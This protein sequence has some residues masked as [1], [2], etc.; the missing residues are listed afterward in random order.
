M[1]TPDG[2]KENLKYG[3]INCDMI[4]DSIYSLNKRAQNW[5]EQ[6]MI[7]KGRGDSANAAHAEAQIA[8]LYGK[9]D[10]LLSLLSPDRIHRE[11]VYGKHIVSASDPA[12]YDEALTA[13]LNRSLCGAVYD[14]KAVLAVEIYDSKPGY[15]Y[16]LFYPFGRHGFHKPVDFET[17]E[18]YD[19]PRYDIDKMQLG[20]LGINDVVSTAFI[21]RLLDVVRHGQYVLSGCHVSQRRS[22]AYA[23]KGASRGFPLLSDVEKS[24]VAPVV[25]QLQ[26][27][28]QEEIFKVIADAGDEEGF[29]LRPM[30]KG[31]IRAWYARHA[32]EDVDRLSVSQVVP[33]GFPLFSFQSDYYAL[34]K[35]QM[36]TV[37]GAAE[38]WA[39]KHR[40]EWRMFM[41]S[42][43]YQ[44]RKIDYLKDCVRMP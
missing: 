5:R 35:A 32:T 10:I 36:H 7:Y 12:F 41:R 18:G 28:I 25:T 43:W 23:E 42:V 29:I 9:K 34:Y 31:R 17:V 2:Y 37:R 11:I 27:L 1:Q 39:H 21:D 22:M 6:A 15:R 3:L 19:L 40:L 26:Q 13:Y 38:W 33:K 24:A 4:C 44:Q 8:D 20:G 30:D 14:G 16:Y